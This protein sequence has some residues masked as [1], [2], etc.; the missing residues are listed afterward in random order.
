MT[1]QQTQSFSFSYLYY[2]AWTQYT[3]AIVCS[4]LNSIQFCLYPKEEHHSMKVVVQCDENW[5]SISHANIYFVK[6]AVSVIVVKH[7]SILRKQFYVV[8]L[9][10]GW[11]CDHLGHEFFML[12]WSF[13]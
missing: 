9:F 11:F 4:E 2:N 5:L 3:I 6:V 7:D 1:I 12:W 13:W 8:D 10:D